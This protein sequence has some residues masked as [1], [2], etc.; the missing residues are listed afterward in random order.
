M[1][2]NNDPEATRRAQD[3]EANPRRESTSSAHVGRGG[4]AN[5]F[6]PSKEDIEKARRENARLGGD[7]AVVFDDGSS[8]RAGRK[9]LADRGKDW[10]LGKTSS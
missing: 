10:L 1:A 7:S 6:K 4:A 8:G 9:G 5:V 2:K 3:V